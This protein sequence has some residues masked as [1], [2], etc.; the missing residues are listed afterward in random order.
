MFLNNPIDSSFLYRGVCDSQYELL[1]GVFRKQTDRAGSHHIVNGKYLAWVKEKDLLLS[2]IHEASGILSLAPV[3][4]GRWAEYAQHYGVPTRFLDW[5]S[6]PLVALYFAC[7]DNASCN[8]T[9]WLLHKTNY[10]K[11][12]KKFGGY[13]TTQNK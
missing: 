1:P 7:R 2:F 6:N 8:G 5:S 12:L 13:S 9:V 4:L 11:F 10:K 3:D